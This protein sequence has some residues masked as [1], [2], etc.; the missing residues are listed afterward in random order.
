MPVL[1]LPGTLFSP[2]WKPDYFLKNHWATLNPGH[3]TS[4]YSRSLRNSHCEI[5]VLYIFKML[6]AARKENAQLMH[7]SCLGRTPQRSS[8]LLDPPEKLCLWSRYILS[9]LVASFFHFY[10]L[11]RNRKPR[12]L[13]LHHKTKAKLLVRKYLHKILGRH[14]FLVLIV[15]LCLLWFLDIKHKI[16]LKKN[17]CYGGKKLFQ[18]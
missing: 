6:A 9:T 7:C 2:P 8:S 1:S 10:I 12:F 5:L 4:I 17:L 18:I 14:N 16:W 11:H 15:S 3:L 13:R